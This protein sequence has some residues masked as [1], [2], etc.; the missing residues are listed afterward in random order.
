MLSK[1]VFAESIA[2]LGEIYD[3]KPSEQLMDIY[4][5]VLSHFTD[6]QLKNAIN[7]I[8]RTN[9]FSAMPKPAEILEQI[10]GKPQDKGLEAW[11]I[12]LEAIR[13]VGGYKTPAFEDKAIMGVINH[14]GGWVKL[15]DTTKEE[16][17]WLKKE[18]EKLYPV[19]Q[20]RDNSK[21]N[22]IGIIDKENGSDTV[23]LPNGEMHKSEPVRI[24]KAK[25]ILAIKQ[26]VGR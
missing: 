23:M 8:I 22:L 11:T 16:M 10:E 25:D 21:E 14:I 7:Q 24:G 26:G 12:V 6:E 3:K 20:R 2:I 4:Y 13:S 5:S 15:C 17:V 1:R 19:F 18:F 9:K